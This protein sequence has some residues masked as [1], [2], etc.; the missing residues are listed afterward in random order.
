MSTSPLSNAERQELLALY[1]DLRVADVRDGLDT[2]MHHWTG[3]MSPAIRPLWRTRACGIAKTA[4]HVPFTGTVPNMTPE[5]YWAWSG[6][7]YGKINPYP[8]MDDIQPGDFIVIDQSGVDAGLMGSNNSMAGFKSG[9]VG[10]VSSGG[11]RDTDELILQKIP[12]WSPFISQKMVQARLQYDTKDV[13]VS[14]GGVTVHPGD[15][16]VADG[17]GVI[18]VPRA[19]AKDV[20]KWG[21]EEHTRDKATRRKLYQ[22]LGKPLDETV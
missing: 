1:R 13:P 21:G 10:Y 11:V 4:R 5:Q 6:E 16:V 14:V 8:W 18:V 2:M 20:A 9:A 7:Y 22:D 17:D 15:V 19:L 12:F 3:S